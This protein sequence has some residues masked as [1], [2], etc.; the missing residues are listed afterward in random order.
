MN[1]YLI[2]S[3]IHGDYDSFRKIVN[4]YR[5]DNFTKLILL[6]DILYHGPRNPLVNGYYPKR[7]YELLN[8]F[9]SKEV[10]LIRGNCDAEVDQMV[11]DIPFHHRKTIKINNRTIHL[12][13]GHHLEEQ[14]KYF[15]SGDIVFY[16]HTHE[17]KIEN[18]DGIY[19]INPGSISLPKV[20]KE[21]TYIIFDSSSV[22]I[23]DLDNNKVIKES[24]LD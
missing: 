15:R 12:V 4:I 11:I 1:K 22:K 8:T 13:H 21:R 20:N 17:Y 23:I 7:V 3:D 24:L 18:I 16:G 9:D 2:V 5:R 14:K 19:Y 10:I 6:G